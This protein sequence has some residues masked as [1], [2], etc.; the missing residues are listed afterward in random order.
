MIL[1]ACMERVL[2][3]GLSWPENKAW[4][5][6]AARM[7]ALQILVDLVHIVQAATSIRLAEALVGLVYYMPE[8]GR[9]MVM[10]AAVVVE[11]AAGT[12]RGCRVGDYHSPAEVFGMVAVGRVSLALGAENMCVRTVEGCKLEASALRVGSLPVRADIDAG[13]QTMLGYLTHMTAVLAVASA[14]KG[15]P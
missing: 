11:V 13:S 1:V 8:H 7:S 9:R 12:Q 3:V 6:I 4:C 15:L 5:W 2:V 10:S 14:E